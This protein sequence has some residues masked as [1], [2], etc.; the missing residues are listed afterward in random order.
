MDKASFYSSLEALL[1]SS[2]TTDSEVLTTVLGEA[3]VVVEK[4]KAL[5]EEQ[6]EAMKRGGWNC[7]HNQPSERETLKTVLRKMREREEALEERERKMALADGKIQKVEESQSDQVH[8]N[9]GGKVFSTTKDTLIKNKDTML[10]A[11]FS[12]RHSLSADSQGRY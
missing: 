10:A 11:M 4:L 1:T 6:D 12:G 3:I 9:V 7:N 2:S 8:F 5:V